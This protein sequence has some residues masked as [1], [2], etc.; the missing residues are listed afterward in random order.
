[1][2]SKLNVPCVARLRAAWALQFRAD[3][4]R[5]TASALFLFTINPVGFAALSYLTVRA[6]AATRALSPSDRAGLGQCVDVGGAS[7]VQISPAISC[8]R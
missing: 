4:Y 3:A 5:R 1:M 8:Q 2:R 6:R 7:V